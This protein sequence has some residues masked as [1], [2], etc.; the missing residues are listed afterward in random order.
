[1]KERKRSSF[2]GKLL[3]IEEVDLCI[4]DFREKG[5]VLAKNGFARSSKLEPVETSDF[6][7]DVKSGVWDLEV[8]WNG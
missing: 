6:C 2:S 4:D 8:L 5:L 1:M 7:C 3:G